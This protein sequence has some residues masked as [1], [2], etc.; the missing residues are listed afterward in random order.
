MLSSTTTNPEGKMRR[1]PNKTVDKKYVGFSVTF[2]PELLQALDDYC[3]E[4]NA[5][6][7]VVLRWA[8]KN[9]LNAAKEGSV[10]S[11]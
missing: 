10:K 9:W 4:H 2:S 1:S 5:S 3:N 8:W 6:R 11:P 7:S